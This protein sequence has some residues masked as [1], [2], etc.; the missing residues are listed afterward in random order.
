MF[1]RI[2]GK[3]FV[4]S[5]KLQQGQL[6]QV[7][8]IQESNRARLGVIAVAEKLMTVVQAEEINALQATMD[9]RFGDLAIERGYLNQ[10]Q[11]DRLLS[12]QGNEFL[13]F[14]QAIV[15]RGFM[16]LEEVDN[17]ISSY[18]REKGLTDE[19]MNDLK[20]GDMEKIVPIFVDS[21][22]EEYRH[23]FTY[24]IKN[25]YR[26]V[27]VHMTIDNS[28]TGHAIQDECVGYQQ[29]NGDLKATV[30]ILGKDADIQKVAKSYTK[31]EFIETRED[32]LD[33]MCE[34]INC[35]NGLYAT[36]KSKQGK[37]IDLE[38]PIFISKFAEV[39]G[40]DLHIM[41]VHSSGSTIYLVISMRDD[42]SVK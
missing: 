20:S 9:K 28:K 37:R 36:D 18:Q 11:V 16:T 33:A 8:Q 5:G 14:T 7:Y 27:D 29:F 34:L 42:V 4:D 38:P 15:D 24:G 25:I 23:L 12:L 2:M 35:I 32:A 13:T 10:A 40:D 19:Q 3:Y 6:S 21:Q 17:A 39:S 1:D 31:E 41:P 30:A 26:L 22:D